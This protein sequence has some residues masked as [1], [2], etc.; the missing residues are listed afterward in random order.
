MPMHNAKLD[1]NG[2]EVQQVLEIS[3]NNNQDQLNNG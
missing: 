2:Y 3:F 1:A